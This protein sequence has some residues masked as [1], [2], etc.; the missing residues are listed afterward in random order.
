MEPTSH[1]PK[2]RRLF[3]PAV[4]L[5]LFLAAGIWWLARPRP[6]SVVGEV[7]GGGHVLCV[8]DDFIYTWEQIGKDYSGALVRCYDWSGKPRWKVAYPYT[9]LTQMTSAFPSPDG[10]VLATVAAG[11]ALTVQTW[12]DGKPDRRIDLHPWRVMP[13]AVD[14]VVKVRNDGS[15]LLA[16]A[17]AFSPDT[18]LYLL[19][20]GT[21]VSSSRLRGKPHPAYSAGKY[22]RFER[23][24]ADNE[25]A[26]LVSQINEIEDVILMEYVP[27]QVTAIRVSTTHGKYLPP[28]SMGGT[29][30]GD[31]TVVTPFGGRYNASG[32]LAP[33]TT[34]SWYQSPE[35]RCAV[36]D[37]YNDFTVTPWKHGKAG[38]AWRVKTPEG[39]VEARTYPAVQVTPDGTYALTIGEKDPHLPPIVSEI[40]TR[41]GH[42]R[43][44]S[45][46]YLG[47]Q[48]QG[49][50]YLSR[51]MLYRRPGRVMARKTVTI[52]PNQRGQQSEDMI[53]LDLLEVDERQ[54]ALR[55]KSHLHF[56]F[57]PDGTRMLLEAYK[58]NRPLRSNHLIF[59]VR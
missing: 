40:N 6:L 43:W 31:G 9:Y 28:R 35:G 17:D 10:H 55:D 50:S 8:R 1:K 58:P 13:A 22:L 14:C 52:I 51:F 39:Y 38:A 44:L 7:A 18:L 33:N 29:L 27:L 5:L 4:L 56:Y 36:E 32:K 30:L 20:G 48:S 19:E 26:M 15:L 24:I 49:G 12:R 45:R 47:D 34:G 42:P 37:T 25:R 2:R 41:L 59:R 23:Q 46:L 11:K 54:V 21:V 16:C 3:L 53:G 57:K